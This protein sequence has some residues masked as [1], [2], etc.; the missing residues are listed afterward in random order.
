MEGL[1]LPVAGQ[2]QRQNAQVHVHPDADCRSLEM[3]VIVNDEQPPKTQMKLPFD[4][5]WW[6]RAAVTGAVQ[7]ICGSPGSLETQQPGW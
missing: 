3:Q 1:H 7:G 5:Q 6:E 2:V 4:S